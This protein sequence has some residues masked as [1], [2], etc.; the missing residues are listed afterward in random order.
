MFL[1][2]RFSS[3]DEKSTPLL[4]KDPPT[5]TRLV[6]TDGVSFTVPADLIETKVDETDVKVT[7]TITHKQALEDVMEELPD[8]IKEI[9]ANIILH[10]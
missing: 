8:G 6:T 7:R 1:Q 9:V 3:S 2:K 4:P 10:A 5:L